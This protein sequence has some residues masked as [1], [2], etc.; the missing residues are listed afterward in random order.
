[1]NDYVFGNSI[2]YYFPTVRVL[3]YTHG[4]G[5]ALQQKIKFLNTISKSVVTY[6]TITVTNISN[7]IIKQYYGTIKKF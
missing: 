4:Q 5:T 3:Y 7:N 6:I 1:M 2:F